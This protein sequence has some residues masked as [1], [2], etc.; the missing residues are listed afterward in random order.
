M[1]PVHTVSTHKA[2]KV[3]PPAYTVSAQRASD[4]DLGVSRQ[5]GKGSLGCMNSVDIQGALVKAREAVSKHASP[6]AAWH[7]CAAHGVAA[8][9]S[10]QVRC[11]A[12]ALVSHRE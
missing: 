10:M 7:G 3:V 2:L 11:T 4:V 12:A 8:A 6:R 5:R 9:C 1:P